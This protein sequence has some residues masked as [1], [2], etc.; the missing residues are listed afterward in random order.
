MK[1]VLL[2][3]VL[4]FAANVL[5]AEETPIQSTKK[6]GLGY[7]DNGLDLVYWKN[8]NKGIQANIRLSI[9]KER[10]TTPFTNEVGWNY[11]IGF[12]F[13]K[14]LKE[15]E[16]FKTT[17][18]YGLSWNDIKDVRS[19]SAIY[20]TKYLSFQVGPMIEIFMPFCKRLSLVSSLKLGLNASWMKYTYDAS[21]SDIVSIDI[22]GSGFTLDTISLRYYF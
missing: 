1:K 21:K 12:W 17:L 16:Y 13:L 15:Y 7:F 19:S 5:L 20:C 22:S 9:A 3:L 14:K 11:R 18:A 6:I 2:V 4:M 8:D 10:D